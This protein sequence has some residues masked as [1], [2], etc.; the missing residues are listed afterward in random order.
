[1]E[2]LYKIFTFYIPLLL[3][4]CVH[5]YAHA[6]T[7]KKKGDLTA[8]M[9]GR[10]SLNPSVHIDLLGTVIL[11]L[12]AILFSGLPVF[13]WAKP[14]PVNSGNLKS[15]KN[16]LFWIALAGPLSNFLLALFG[17]L[18]IFVLYAFSFSGIL[19]QAFS[20]CE[21][22]IYINLLLAFF[23]LIPLHPLDGAKVLARFLPFEWNRWLED[24]QVYSNMILIAIFILGG[25]R[26]IAAPAD[27]LT[28]IFTN[29][30][31][32]FF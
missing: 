29:W 23:N 16:D 1:M 17:S 2:I 6:W 11:P 22:F 28:Q 27:V 31:R 7:A 8:E 14:V 3:S 12:T 10:L 9:E 24:V 25:F 18:V 21:I 20:W 30:P 5:E 13:G 32:I 19:K 26:Y 15:P 4:L